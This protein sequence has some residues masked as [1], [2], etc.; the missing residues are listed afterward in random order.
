MD[1]QLPS[2]ERTRRMLER[3]PAMTIV[4]AAFADAERYVD[5]RAQEQCPASGKLVRECDGCRDRQE[6]VI[7]DFSRP[8]HAHEML[9]ML[10]ALH[11][12]LVVLLTKAGILA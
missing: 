7:F 4:K 10:E 8:P 6:L 5:I 3:I 12:R 9:A 2:S 1:N 11:M